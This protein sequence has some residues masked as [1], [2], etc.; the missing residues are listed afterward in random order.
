MPARDPPADN[1]YISDPDLD[2]EPVEEMSAAEAEEQAETLREA[3]RY[4][5]TRYY[6]EADPIIADRTYDRLFDRLQELEESFGLQ[7]ADSPTQRVGG[8]PLDELGTVEHVVPMLSIDSGGEAADLREFDRRVRQTVEDPEYVCE[9]K[10]DGLSIEIVYEDGIYERA[11]TRG[12]GQTGEEVTE[13]VATIASV[14]FRLRGDPPSFLAI[15]GEIYMPRSA[16]QELNRERVERGE[17]PFA[18]PRN[19]AAGTLRQLDPSVTADRPLAWFAYDVLAAGPSEE[20]AAAADASSGPMAETALQSHREEHVALEEWG[21]PVNDRFAVVSSAED[22]IDYRDELLAAREDLDYEIDGAVFKVNDRAACAELGSTASHYRW[23]FA[24]KFP[25]RSEETR[26]TDIVIQVGRTGRLTPVALL[27]PVEVSGVTVSRASLHNQSEIEEMGVDVGDTVRI[28]R[29]GDVI[30]YVEEVIDAATE[31]H[32]EFPEECPACGSPVEREGPLHYC[33]GGLTC[34]AQLVQRVAYFGSED[35]LDID[36]L[37]EETAREFVEAGLIEQDVADLY[38][39][40]ASELASRPGWGEQSAR[41]LLSELEAS[42]HPPLADFL[43]ALGI[44]EVGPTLAR[45]LAR[46]FGTLDAV[47]DASAEELQA[48]DG[49]GETVARRVVE[50][51]ENEGNRRVIERLRERGVDPQTVETEGGGE[52]EGLTVVFTGSIEGFTRDE[53]Q[54]L[55]ETHGGSATESVSGNTDYLVAGANPGQSKQADAADHDVEVID[56]G[57][58]FDLLAERGVEVDARR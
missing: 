18:N 37:G 20:A 53:L 7:T 30:P 4:H 9:P 1:P 38:D 21:V 54:E 14:P 33:T 31:G 8:D 48:V 49:V 22:A 3:I 40:T 10:F 41:N 34:P 25:A 51:F 58:F 46:H 13:N 27:E 39:L 6:V 23:A 24:Y 32:F 42:K 52:L 12:D 29:A 17:D 47:I 43:A 36:G 15:R 44:P 55:V 11:A 19:A 56:P 45:D 28:E 16:F 57:P 50:F 5:D 35:G 2:F 26:I